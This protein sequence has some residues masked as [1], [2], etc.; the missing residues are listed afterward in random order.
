MSRSDT[1]GLGPLFERSRQGDDAAR[2][3]LLLCL[4][5]YLKALAHSWLGPE[6]ARRLDASSIAQ[7][8]VVRIEAH[9]SDLRGRSVPQLLAWARRIA[10]NVAADRVRRLGN[11]AAAAEEAGDV[12]AS[13]AGPFDVL[14]GEEE[15]ARVAAAL[16][17]LSPPRREVIVARLLDGLSFEAVAERMGKQ[18]GAVRVLFLRAVEQLRQILGDQT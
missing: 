17:Q 10:H 11:A 3:E 7:E 14:A 15:A 4:R 8:S 13:G 2:G 18:S 16:E 9:W 5:A 12:P 1:H 6:L